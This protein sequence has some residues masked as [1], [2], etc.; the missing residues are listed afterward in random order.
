M[1]RWQPAA[2]RDADSRWLPSEAAGLGDRKAQPCIGALVAKGRSDT[3]NKRSKG[4][5]GSQADQGGRKYLAKAYRAAAGTKIAAPP[6]M[7]PD[8]DARPRLLRAVLKRDGGFLA[9]STAGLCSSVRNPK[10]DDS[11][12]S[13]ARGASAVQLQPPGDGEAEQLQVSPER[14]HTELTLDSSSADTTACMCGRNKPPD[15][16]TSWASAVQGPL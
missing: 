1:L 12:R 6:A 7:L 14:R 2:D 5:A 3:G 9:L 10:A 8:T 4:R 16:D 13:S 15:E 11:P